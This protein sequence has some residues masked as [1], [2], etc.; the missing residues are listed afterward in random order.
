[1]RRKPEG[2]DRTLLQR[3]VGIGALHH[4]IRALRV[5]DAVE[6]LL[7][8]RPVVR[9]LPSG[10]RYRI[11]H[12]ESFVVADEIFRREGYQRAFAGEAIET[13]V[14]LGCNVGYFPCYAAEV[15]ARR[16]LIGLAIDANSEMVSETRW[17]AEAN[18]LTRTAVRFGAV[19]FPADVEEVTFYLAKSNVASSAQPN[20]NPLVPQKG[21]LR[22]VKVPTIDLMRAWREHAG[23]RGIDLLKIDV[24]GC[25]LDVIQTIGDV[26]EITRSL[27]IEWHKWV[28]TRDRVEQA[29]TPHGLTLDS[30]IGEDE[31]AGVAVFRRC[32]GSG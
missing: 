18:G 1:M 12:L 11:R 16:D 2:A 4:I 29:L 32:V 5:Q 30:L 24:E 7:T 15:T 23:D 20:Q 25:E 17:H 9:E 26:L 31:H 13:F 22:P 19:G 6:G 27:V 21:S 8:V 10:I 3:L 28:V 14:D